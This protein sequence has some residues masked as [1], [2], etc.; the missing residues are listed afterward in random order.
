MGKLSP[1]FPICK[2]HPLPH[3]PF[4]GYLI[5]V[6]STYPFPARAP[7]AQSLARLLLLSLSAAV[8]V[9]EPCQGWRRTSRRL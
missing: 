1:R 6:S 7:L 8:Y 3:P 5:R 2:L 9:C 4:H